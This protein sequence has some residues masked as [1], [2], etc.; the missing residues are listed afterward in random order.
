M[1]VLRVFLLS[2]KVERM[3][4]QHQQCQAQIRQVMQL[5]L[6]ALLVQKVQTLTQKAL[7]QATRT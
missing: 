5:A 1:T 7:R 4:C 6:L 3:R 2:A